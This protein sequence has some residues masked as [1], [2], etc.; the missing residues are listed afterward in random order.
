MK[1]GAWHQFGDRS[2]KL[3]LEQLENGVGVGVIFSVR[4]L[5][6]NN[7]L[8]YAQRYKQL[9]ADVLIDQQFYNPNFVNRNLESYPIFRYRQAISQ[10]AQLSDVDLINIANELRNYH[11][12]IGANGL[13]AP[14]V[15]YQAGRSDIT[16]L[17]R[18]LFEV[19]KTVG[20]EIGI[21]T[22]ATVMLDRSVTA[23]NQTVNKIISEVT[24]LNSDGWY[25]GFEFNDER[26]PSSYELILRCC[27]AGLTLACTGKPVLYSYAGPMALLALGFG[28]TGA[29]IGH[30]Q[31]LWHFT[32]Q[33]FEQTVRSG[34]GDA[35]PRFF[36][37]SL[38]GTIIYPDETAQLSANLRDRILNQSPY[39]IPTAT[40]LDWSRW[41][42]NKHIVSA[43]C[44]TVTEIANQSDDPRNNAQSAIDILGN[45]IQLHQEISDEGIILRD[46][47][48]NYQSNWKLAVENL[49]N[50]NSDDYDLLDLLS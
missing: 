36:S 21:P 31:N 2:Q 22:Y 37:K 25:F 26:I 18:R 17:N 41:D 30:S 11:T 6:W 10:L 38:W 9:G 4:D 19:S 20:D 43:I 28:A 40:G 48:N 7:A 14:A 15:M 45:A 29:A 32:R 50:D 24:A 3:A 12:Q 46:S 1:R 33:R 47:S 42:A 49:L 8:A 13:I 44:E 27:V 16:E 39:S 34:G 23:S 35:P 5:K